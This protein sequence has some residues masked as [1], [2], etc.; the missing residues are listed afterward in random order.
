MIQKKVA[1]HSH[2]KQHNFGVP[3]QL[4]DAECPEQQIVL[5]VRSASFT[6]NNNLIKLPYKY[7]SYKRYT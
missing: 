4:T 5:Y 2:V 7:N 6:D 3:Q 1:K